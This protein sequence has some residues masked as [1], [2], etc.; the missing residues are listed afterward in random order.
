MPQRTV[1]IASQLGLHARPATLFV[2]AVN[3]SGLPVMVSREGHKPVD[4]RSVLAVMAMG[5][6]H[7]ETV[8]L[9]CE[10][11]ENADKVLDGLVDM[12]SKDLDA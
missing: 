4:A 1:A 9:S 8:T 3:E 10:D 5:A 12:L 7:G 11:S 2:Q 6:K